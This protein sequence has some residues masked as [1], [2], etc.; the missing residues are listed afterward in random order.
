[1]ISRLPDLVK[2]AGYVPK[3]GVAPLEETDDRVW[4]MAARAEKA[5]K[6][7]SKRSISD[8]PAVIKSLAPEFGQ[9]LG[10]YLEYQPS[11]MAMNQLV[12]QLNTV[13]SAELGR[14]ISLT[15]PLSSGFVPFDLL[16]PSRLI[17]PV[18]SP[19]RNKLPRTAGQGTSRRVKYVN[20]ISGSRTGGSTG[21]STRWSIGEFPSGGGFGNW[22]NQLP[23]AGSQSANDF[24]VDY[25]FF[26]L[27]ESLTWLAQFSG[28]GFED[29]SALANLILL[30]EAMIAEE[31]AIFSG[32]GT[33]VETPGTPSLSERT[34]SSAET[35]L[36]GIT[37]NVFVKV[38]ALN[39]YGE[40]VASTAGELSD[41]T[42]GDVVDVVI[43][44]ARGAF[45]YNIYATTGSSAGTYY[46][47]NSSPVGCTKYTL[48]SGALVTSGTE[49]PSSDSGTGGSNDFEG[50]MSI[51]DGH[52]ITDADIYPSGYSGVGVNKSAAGILSLGTVYPVLYN[53][54]DQGSTADGVAGAYRA[55]PAELICEGSDAGRLATDLLTN[56]AD[57]SAY[58]AFIS[59]DEVGGI[60]TGAAV[61]EM[62][63]PITRAVV[64]ILVHPWLT[65]G[66]AFLMSYTLPMPWSN[67]TNT[68]E[69]VM[70]Q[71]LL[72]VA[73]PV[74][75]ATFRYSIFEY[76]SLIAY[77]PQYSSVIGGLQKSATPPYN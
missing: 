29:I 27:S 3:G 43:S 41:F 22:P 13:L 74:I 56:N 52:A 77:A 28:Q 6:D 25:H 58:R 57:A 10:A 9:Q 70:V 51:L 69:M 64:K 67:V 71:D 47:Q 23:S 32:T 16:A 37:D 11:N 39:Y 7:A 2:G 60:R 40:T 49:P 26:G 46:L 18:Y 55:N 14:N 48:G 44:P 34:P 36:T 62:Q 45:Q 1:M 19:M 65:Q 72:S 50:L 4:T 24:N 35:A 59:Q 21:A 73:W 17:Y 61:S 42:T 54:W 31:D 68:F 8:T 15:S 20:A 66:T 76:G 5:L 75:D 30:Q 63:N 38:T 53:L 12:S 33:D